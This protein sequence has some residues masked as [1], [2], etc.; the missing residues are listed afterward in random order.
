[1]TFSNNRRAKVATGWEGL[2]RSDL[3]F[4]DN[5][6]TIW[7]KPPRKCWGFC[8]FCNFSTFNHFLPLCAG[9]ANKGLEN[10]QDSQQLTTSKSG[11]KFDKRHGRTQANIECHVRITEQCVEATNK[12]DAFYSRNSTTESNF[13]EKEKI[14]ELENGS[15]EIHTY[16]HTH[17]Q[18]QQQKS[19]KG[20][21]PPEELLSL[22][23]QRIKFF[24]S[25]GIL[26]DS[27]NIA[28]CN[29]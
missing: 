3:Q 1:M 13:K 14:E 27:K 24:S 7:T 16:T 21:T 6:L 4:S 25:K 29:T 10:Y 11:S 9:T 28:A 26:L 18:G 12:S 22:E 5:L 23:Q 20:K 15:S 8:N 2:H 19:R 17:T